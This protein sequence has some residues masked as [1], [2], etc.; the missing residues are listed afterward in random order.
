MSLNSNDRFVIKPTQLEGLIV[1]QRKPLGDTR[2]YF[3]RLFC[4]QELSTI[5]KNRRIVQINH[6][7]TQKQGTVRGLHYQHPPYAEMKFVTCIKGEIFDVAVD[8]RKG[9][10]TFLKW[11]AEI[12][13]QDNFK[14]LVI[15]EGFAHGFQT[16]VDD[17]ELMYLHTNFYSPHKEGAIRYDEPLVNVSWP[18]PITEISKRDSN[19]SYLCKDF[20]GIA[21]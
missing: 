20:E 16:L 21:T 10:P 2:G 14:T 8:I 17:C 19:H 9:S 4:E 1:I 15:P 5:L 18:L 7:R 12:L 11:H 3:E 6:T 13:S